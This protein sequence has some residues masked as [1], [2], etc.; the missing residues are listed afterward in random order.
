MEIIIYGTIN[1]LILVLMSAG[2]ALTYSVSRVPNFA[3]GALYVLGGYL[4]WIFLN[5]LGIHYGLSIFLSIVVV[6]LIGLLIYGLAV[7]RVRGMPL[8][9]IIMTFAISLAILEFL[10]WWGLRGSTFVL[11]SFYP[12]TISVRGVPIDMQ[13]I[14]AMTI[15]ACLI[16]ALWFFTHYTRIGLGLRAIA[17]NERAALLLGVRSDRSAALA[18]G[19][20]SGLAAIAGITILPMGNINVATGYDVLVLA[21]SVCICGGLGSW[22]GTV[23]AAFAI[24]FA[25]MLVVHF[26]APHF[27]MIVSLTAIILILLFK[28]SGLYGQQKELEERV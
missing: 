17:Q 9:E 22:T 18:L 20:G 16:L 6:T 11:P 21:I 26:I 27:G 5:H 15:A 13:R 1:S 4:S 7:V 24:G 3:H 19:L 2:F 14:F 23:L 10:R 12:G 8:S 25:Q 28:P